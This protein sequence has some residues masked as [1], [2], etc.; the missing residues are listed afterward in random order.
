[1]V[2]PSGKGSEKAGQARTSTVTICVCE[3]GLEPQGRPRRDRFRTTRTLHISIFRSWDRGDSE[4]EKSMILQ[5]FRT[6]FM[7]IF[8]LKCL[9]FRPLVEI[10]DHP[11][12]RGGIW[13]VGNQTL[14]DWTRK[15]LVGTLKKWSPDPLP[16]NALLRMQRAL[17]QTVQTKTGT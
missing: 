1:M 8:H 7:K 12:L 3:P 2:V 14:N 9:F 16:G 13:G 17:S 11:P 15:T 10:W 4:H 5:L 6:V